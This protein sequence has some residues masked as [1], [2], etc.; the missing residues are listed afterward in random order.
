MRPGSASR[1]LS[2]TIGPVAYGMDSM[3]WRSGVSTFTSNVFVLPS[4]QGSSV[5]SGRWSDHAVPFCTEEPTKCFARHVRPEGDVGA[6][7]GA[8]TEGAGATVGCA[9]G[10]GGG[11]AAGLVAL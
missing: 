1:V 11:E 10:A 2:G 6:A 3:S 7:G 5:P 4:F 8:G 9:V